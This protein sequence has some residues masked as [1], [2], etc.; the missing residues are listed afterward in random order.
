MWAKILKYLCEQKE[1]K[2]K[3]KLKIEKF[4]DPNGTCILFWTTII[5]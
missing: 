3:Q 5:N 1:Q 4:P 2:T